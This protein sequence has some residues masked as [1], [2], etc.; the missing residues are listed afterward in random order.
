MMKRIFTV[1]LC[2]IMLL[3]FVSC[4]DNNNDTQ[5]SESTN[6]NEIDRKDSAV[7]NKCFNV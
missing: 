6:Q 1:I 4:G 2:G 5:S 3:C 7:F